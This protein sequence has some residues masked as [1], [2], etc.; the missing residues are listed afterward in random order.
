MTNI[1][2]KIKIDTI[3]TAYGD[4]LD[5][6]DYDTWINFFE[7]EC[8]YLVQSRENF[9]RNFP[10]ALIRLVSHNMM[11]DRVYGCMDTIFHQLYYQRHV[12]GGSTIVSVE[13]DIVTTRTNYAVFR[14]KPTCSS[15]V[16][17]VGCYRDCWRIIDT[18]L[19]LIERKCIYDSEMVLNA[20]IYPI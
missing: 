8:L 15:E 18:D 12:I 11:K 4:A 19:K 17:N 9:D 20:L 16:F 2:L 14:S 13:D 5:S 1:E 7:S 10:L 3:N 6:H